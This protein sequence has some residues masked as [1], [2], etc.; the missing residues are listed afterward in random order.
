M[1]KF[2]PILKS[3]IWGGSRIIS[4]KR[5]DVRLDDVGES[6]EISGVPGMETVVESGPDAG[7]TVTQL[8]DKYGPALMGEK[9][10]KKY[11]DDF[12]L[13]VKF[14][15]A[16]ADLSVQV[17]PDGALAQ[18]R[19]HKWGKTEMWYIVEAAKG[20]RVASGFRTPVDPADYDSLVKSGRIEDVLGYID[21]RPGEVYMTPA[22]RVHAIGR[23]CFLVEIQQT[24][25][26]TYRI[27]DY[28]RRDSEGK[29]RELHTELAR[30][31]ID[32]NDTGVEAIP[33]QQR[34][35]VP[36]TVARTPYFITNVLNADTDLLR[37]YSESD[38]F[39]IL[40]MVDG[41]AEIT[42]GSE[43]VKARRGQSLLVPAS[44]T[45]ITITPVKTCRIIETYIK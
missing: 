41:E 11:G 1:W 27:Y 34:M 13:L 6:W 7:L 4:F 3:T 38:T 40:V 45:G 44:A 24:S 12:P 15:D 39:V 5:L 29:E 31:G 42:C 30:E 8:V 17:H 22:G 25:D 19:G 37:D 28:H 18:R 43:S 20:A 10:Y 26:L 21:V 23:G 36:V 33:Y 9:N 14:I 2:K 16:R 32:F 35:N